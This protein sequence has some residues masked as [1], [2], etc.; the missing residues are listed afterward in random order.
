MDLMTLALSKKFTSDAIAEAVLNGVQGKSAYEI[1]VDNGFLGTEKEWLESL[2]GKTP[3]IGENNNWFIGGVD[4]GILAV[5]NLEEYYHKADLVAL[6]EE[7]ILE[8]C[9]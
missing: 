2:Q 3:Y 9:K 1:A 8:I 5:P 7:E 4:T 6:T